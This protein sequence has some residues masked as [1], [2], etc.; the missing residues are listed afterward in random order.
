MTSSACAL[1]TKCWSSPYW[2]HYVHHF[3]NVTAN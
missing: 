2:C 1:E 3:Y